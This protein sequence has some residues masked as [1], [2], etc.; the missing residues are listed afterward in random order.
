[1]TRSWLVALLSGSL[2]G[3]G[4]ARDIDGIVLETL[5]AI[6]TRPV[7]AVPK[8]GMAEALICTVPVQR[9]VQRSPANWGNHA[10]ASVASRS[11]RWG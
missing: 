6:G 1:M 7:I 9:C 3:A 11:H 5:T 2:F 4:L 10:A 8:V